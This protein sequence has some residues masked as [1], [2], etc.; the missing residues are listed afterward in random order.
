M[1]RG[2]SFTVTTDEGTLA[3]WVS[4]DGAPVLLLHGGP[5]LSYGYMDELADEIGGGFQLATYQQRGIEPSS[6]SGPFTVA[7]AI[8]DAIAVLDHLG[9]ERASVVGHS[10]GGHLALRLAAAHPARAVAALAVDPLGL[11]GD[12]GLTAMGAEMMAR[13]PPAARAR[14]IELDERQARGEERPGDAVE[15]LRLAWP[16][17][18]ADPFRVAPFPDLSLC[19]EAA[20]GLIADVLGGEGEV[21]G[22]EVAAVLGAAGVRCAF[23]AGAASPMPWGSSSRASADLISGASVTVVPGGGHLP[24]FESPGCVRAALVA[25]THD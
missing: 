7:R 3:G 18:F 15:A 5:G 4:G 22:D 1:S 16:S 2:K 23:L 13:M 9:W 20:G 25:L 21:R 19:T 6:V 24:W 8:G 10:W 14:R 17:Y 11:V 12:G